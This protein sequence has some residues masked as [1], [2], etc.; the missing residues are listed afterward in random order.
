MYY[1][2]HPETGAVYAY[3]SIELQEMYFPILVLMTRQ[4]AIDHLSSMPN[5]PGHLALLIAGILN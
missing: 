5:D 4:E 1:F 2:K 3:E